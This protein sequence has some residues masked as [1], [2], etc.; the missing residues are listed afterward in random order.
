MVHHLAA[1]TRE[2]PQVSLPAERATFS[3]AFRFLQD[4]MYWKLKQH[5][6][7]GENVI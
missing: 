1:F 3:K 6:G 7:D 2:A 5:V 4:L